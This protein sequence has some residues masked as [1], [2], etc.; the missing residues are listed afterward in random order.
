MDIILIDPPYTSLKGIPTDIGYNIGLTSLAAYLRNGGI[1]T[2]I[3]MG[4]LLV[5]L[6]PADGWVSSSL[7]SYALKQAEYNA[8]VK[9]VTHPVWQRLISLVNQHKPK[10][11]GI[12]YLTPL[13]CSV[14]MIARLVK[15][16][17]PDI[18]VIVGGPHPTF[19]P[20]EVL[21]NPNIDY[22]ITGEG[23]IPLLRLVK[24]LK[25]A[26]PELENITGLYYRNGKGNVCHNSLIELIHN[27]DSLPIPARDLVINCDYHK[28][29][30]HC[31]LTARGCPYSCAFCADKSMW[32]GKVRRRSVDNVISE[33]EM[34]VN[35]YRVD[36][37]DI[38]DG[39]FT[40]DKK[41]VR[42]FCEKLIKK[43]IRV[44]WGC[45]ARYDNLDYDLLKIMK[46]ANCSGL[47]FGLESGSDRVLTYVDKKTNIDQITQI[48]DMVNQVGIPSIT[49]VIIGLPD[50]TK[51]DIEAT[52]RIMNNISTDIFDVNSYVPLPGSK[53]YQLSESSQGN[54]I[55]WSKVAFKSFENHFSKSVSHEDLKKYI[56]QA[57]KIADNTRTNTLKRHQQSITV[58]N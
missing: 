8:V 9:N 57:Y 44:N 48:A 26:N 33:M 42:H 25:L 40:Y 28:Y 22:V 13:K 54:N 24:E 15:E 17:N 32:Q 7:E 47:Y 27:L 5:D 36:V 50:E 53:L 14:E 37:I 55:D 41:Y 39:T 38:L 45:T 16:T 11:V 52:L 35:T 34:L 31:I 23:E 19:C 18:S 21:K 12:S 20:E 3:I 46:K 30:V 56:S 58:T 51:E 43:D 29:R 1:E 6:P 2:S 10:A 4:D 49:S